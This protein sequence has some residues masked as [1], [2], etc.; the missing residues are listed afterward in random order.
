[1][2]GPGGTEVGRVSVKVVPDVDGF[3]E[4]VKKELEEVDGMKATVEVEI[5]LAKLKVQIDE[6]KVLLKSIQDETVKLNVEQTGSGAG[7]IARLGEDLKKSSTEADKLGKK[8]KDIVDGDDEKRLGKVAQIA[9]NL[10]TFF[11]QAAQ[12]ASGL[13]G[14]LGGALSQGATSAAGSILSLVTQMVV[15]VPLLTVAFGA[16]VYLG[17]AI[18]ALVAAIP[19]LAAAIGAPIAAIILGFDGIKKA[20]QQLSPEVDKLK[21]RLSSTFTKELTPAFKELAKVFP[22]LSDGLNTVAKQ[23][24]GLITDFTRMV[25]SAKGIQQI[26]DM[27]DGVASFIERLRPG[28]RDFFNAFLDIAST[29]SL[30]DDL[31]DSLG[32]VFK[33][34]ANFFTSMKQ[35]GDLQKAIKS[36]GD[37]L[38]SVTALF[39]SLFKAA[40]RFFN[41]AAPGVNAFFD[42]FGRFAERIDFERLGKAFGKIFEAIGSFLDNL[43]DTT[44]EQ[45]TKTFEGLA[46]AITNLATGDSFKVLV[47]LFGLLFKI[48]TAGLT[49]ID[50]LLEGFSNLGEFFGSIPGKLSALGDSF[51]LLF[52]G[53]G[54]TFQTKI[55]EIGD[56]FGSIPGI[57]RGKLQGFAEFLVIEGSKW[58]DGLK[59]GI[60]SAWTSVQAFFAGIRQNILGFF[61][62][63]GSWLRDKGRQI[64]DGLRNGVVSAFNTVVAFV[65]S[66][67]SKVKGALGDAG[68]WLFSV[69]ANVIQGL[70]NGL[71][72]RVGG[73]LARAAG[74]ASSIIGVIS[75]AFRVG[76]P[77][78]VMFEMGGFIMQGLDNG[79]IRGSKD[80]LST[81][82]SIASNML[83]AFDP[84]ALSAD[85]RVSGSDIAAVGTSQL[86]VAGSVTGVSAEIVEAMSGWNVEIDA[87]GIARLVNKA[88]NV[89][90]RRG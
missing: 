42:S 47:S 44:I 39:T 8:M 36:L 66:I 68:S 54:F 78:R 29:K 72:S 22:A 11:G 32:L 57:V 71:N 69:G 62:D 55:K 7:G 19:V 82:D 80:V 70:L 56:F 18:G 3:R 87:N 38:V 10:G 16:I 49:V 23:V 17:G 58:I 60:V 74:I 15:W 5:D 88:N 86:S 45:F 65:Q 37:T 76:S 84:K 61:G 51:G 81:T 25:S 64:I 1:M 63:V 27:F 20:A 46:G 53:L 73:L 75:G 26:R 28:L 31:G 85:M 4:K 89:R 43:D 9:Q 6:I 48:V 40:I 41:G 35:T 12:S 2:A 34:L 30:F 67:P 83:G 14:Q 21:A 79:L 50:K 59:S 77:S 52:E 24:S 13:A 33:I 90:A